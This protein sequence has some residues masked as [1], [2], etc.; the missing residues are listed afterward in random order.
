LRG[1]RL[2]DRM[3]RRS[4]IKLEK[5]ADIQIDGEIFKNQKEIRLHVGPVIRCIRTRP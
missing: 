2:V 1:E 5:P 3:V 4:V